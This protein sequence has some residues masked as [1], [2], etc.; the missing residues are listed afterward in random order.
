MRRKRDHRV[1]D[2]L[3]GFLRALFKGVSFTEEELDRP[4]IGVVNS[5]G[6]INPATKHLNVLT[7][8]FKISSIPSNVKIFVLSF[9]DQARELWNEMVAN[10]IALEALIGAT[11]IASKECLRTVLKS[12]FSGPALEL[13]LRALEIGKNLHWIV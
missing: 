5:W 4:L 1:P 8:S 3:R 7:I 11:N 6:E 12:R 2:Y 13:N 10:G 9:V